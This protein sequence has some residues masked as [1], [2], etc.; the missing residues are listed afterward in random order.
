MDRGEVDNIEERES[1]RVESEEKEEEARR[2]ERNRKRRERRRLMDEA[3]ELCGLVKV[4]GAVSGR[5]YYE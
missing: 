2:R 5:I 3:A 4:R 1:N